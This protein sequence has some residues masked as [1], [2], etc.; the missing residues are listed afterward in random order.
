MGRAPERVNASSIEEIWVREVTGAVVPLDNG[1][2]IRQAGGPGN[3]AQAAC[4]P[5]K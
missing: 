3:A 5:P 4:P 1:T 2:G